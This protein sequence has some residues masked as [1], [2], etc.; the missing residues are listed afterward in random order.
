M[1]LSERR[2][3]LY[4][5]QNNQTLLIF[6][7]TKTNAPNILFPQYKNHIPSHRSVLLP[8]RSLVLWKGLMETIYVRF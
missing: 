4:R 2:E 7:Y 5:F 1:V 8:F 3:R 6:Y